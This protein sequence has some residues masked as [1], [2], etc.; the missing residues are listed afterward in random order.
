MAAVMAARMVSWLAGPLPVRNLRWKSCRVVVCLD[1]PVPPGQAGLG[2]AGGVS[3]GQAGD[4][5]DGLAGGPAGG[6]VLPPAGDLDGLVGAREV[7]VTDVGGPSGC[8]SRRGRAALAGGTGARC[9]L[10]G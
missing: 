9:L 2:P 10:S 8:G 7:Q 3:A 4:G 6:G 1:G 5:V